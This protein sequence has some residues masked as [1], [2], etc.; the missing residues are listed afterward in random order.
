[1]L[2]LVIISENDIRRLS[3]EIIPS[4][5]EEL[6]QVSQC[7]SLVSHCSL[8]VSL[9]LCFPSLHL[10]LIP[11]S[12]SLLILALFLR[13]SILPLSLHLCPTSTAITHSP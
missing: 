12:A 1:M 9:C 11:S 4:S 3:I 5:V 2:L 13:T 8:L 10:H 7:V 6:C